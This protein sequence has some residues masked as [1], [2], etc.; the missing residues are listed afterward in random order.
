MTIL[1]LITYSISIWM[2]LDR[3]LSIH[4]HNL[5][6]F[7][8]HLHPKWYAIKI[9]ETI[10]LRHHQTL[11][12]PLILQPN[13]NHNPPTSSNQTHTHTRNI[14][15]PQTKPIP[16]PLLSSNH[17]P[18][19]T[20]D[21]S[22]IWHRRCD[23]LERQ[24]QRLCYSLL[25]RWWNR[26]QQ[27]WATCAVVA[28]ISGVLYFVVLRF[29]FYICIVLISILVWFIR[30]SFFSSISFHYRKWRF[31]L[32]QLCCCPCPFKSEFGS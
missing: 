6:F 28:E 19:L 18:P 20:Q 14:I 15:K 9:F 13:L 30:C 12:P 11:A 16:I 21:A 32:Y 1:P 23:G 25:F 8:L 31:I 2:P 22:W 7:Y 17:N 29:L 5:I 4:F 27:W 3:P 26:T 24:R 10:L